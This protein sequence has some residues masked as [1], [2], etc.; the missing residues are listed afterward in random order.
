GQ[1]LHIHSL[2]IGFGRNGMKQPDATVELRLFDEARKPTLLK[3]F[4][5]VVPKDL[6]ATEELVTVYFLVPFN[7]EGNFTAE[8][9]ATDAV[10]KKT[11]TVS[12]PIKVLPAVK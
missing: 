4:V 5:A 12:F 3:P 8:L 9:K 1:N 7:R 10:T 6:N 2:L 11:S